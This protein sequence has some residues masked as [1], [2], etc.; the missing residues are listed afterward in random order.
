MIDC[1]SGG[2]DDEIS[3]LPK[4]Q[5][6]VSGRQDRSTNARSQVVSEVF[7]SR[8]RLVRS[9]VAAKKRPNWRRRYTGRETGRCGL[10]S[11]F[12]F[13]RMLVAL[14]VVRLYALIW[15]DAITVSGKH[16]GVDAFKGYVR[17]VFDIWMECSFLPLAIES[18]Y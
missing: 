6:S 3:Q 4:N 18:S 5:T 13:S 7:V 8:S 17:L 14:A 16:V 10:S 9:V 15:C 1:V 2:I 12:A 11:A